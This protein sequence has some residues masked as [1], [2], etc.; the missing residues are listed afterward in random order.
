MFL[1]IPYC[2]RTIGINFCQNLF[3]REK[4]IYSSENKVSKSQVVLFL[5]QKL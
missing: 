2:L 4:K 5:S 3:T 1:K